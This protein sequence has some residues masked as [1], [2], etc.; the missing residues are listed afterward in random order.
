MSTNVASVSNRKVELVVHV[1]DYLGESRR[2]DIEQALEGE[3]AVL[4]AHFTANRPHL[5]LV[6]Y[7][8]GQISSADVL[9]KVNEQSVHAELVGP[10]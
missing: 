10:I 4:K 2:Q 9:T 7:D 8:A 6:E 1:D 3:Q 5:M